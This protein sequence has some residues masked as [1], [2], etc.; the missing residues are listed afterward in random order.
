MA[1]AAEALVHATVIATAGAAVLIRGAS[2]AGK[3][4]LALRCLTLGTSELLAAPA[5]LVA[6]DQVLIRC[7]AG[8]LTARAPQ[9]IA[10]LIEVRGIGLARVAYVE[11]AE[12]RLVAD[13][14]SPAAVERLPA[15]GR[16]ARLLGC[17]VPLMSLTPF[18]ATAPAKLLLA[19]ARAAGR[20]SFVA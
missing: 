17:E 2:G 12:V 13:L 16:T 18:E 11:E 19:L 15:E 3:S 1:D 6:D 4:D 8:R 5:Q 20:A 10:G 7:V 14:V 9:P